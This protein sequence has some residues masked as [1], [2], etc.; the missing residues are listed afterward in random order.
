[1]IRF[2]LV[3]AA[4]LAALPAAAPPAAARDAE[5]H[6]RLDRVT[7]Y[8]DGASVVRLVTFDL[9]PGET[10]LVAR[11]FPAALDPR[12]LRVEGVGGGVSVLGV[13]A[14]TL[15]AEEQ[16]AGADAL[17]A[18]LDALRLEREGVQSRIE[19]LAVRKSFAERY[20]RDVPFGAGEKETKIPF[21]EWRQTFSGLADE[22]EAAGRAL[23][24]V[25]ERARTLDEAIAK[26]EQDLR[27]KPV[28]RVQVRIDVAAE[29]AAKGTLAVTYSVRNARWTPLY[30][31]RLTAGKPGGT[32]SL[33]LVRRAEIVQR[34]GED[35]TDVALSVSTLRTAG[36]TQAPEIQPVF[37]RFLPPPRPMPAPARAPMLKQSD[38]LAE[39]AAPAAAPPPVPANE[40]PVSEREAQA[41]EGALQVVWTLPG[42]VSVGSGEG[43]RVLR[44]ASATVAP[45]LSVKVSAA[46]DTTPYLQAGF[47]HA[48]DAPLLPGRVA[49]YRDGILVGTGRLDLVTQGETVSLGFGAD[50]RTKVTRT[51]LRRDESQ[52]GLVSQS[53][54]ERQEM[55]ISVRNAHDVPM[56]ITVEDRIPQSEDQDIQVEL[57]SGGTAPTARDVGDRRGVLAW[58]YDYAPGESRTITFGWRV[59][60]PADRQVITATPRR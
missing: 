8:P 19:A 45:D 15:D 46:I 11:D 33:E 60:W 4:L 47:K 59:K 12:S 38:A 9:P 18:K 24:E 43:G 58:S 50:E 34:T 17:K 14:K 42:R 56:R 44:L 49:L 52:S 7:V 28:S 5:V 31:A 29:A 16:P 26:A 23:I 20:A 40:V 53:R 36:G 22:I 41:A 10:T 30:D 55:K 35:W 25:R 32:P 1:M 3:S 2:L 13:V 48:E 39:R 57:A 6:S 54:V 37:V 51:L 21:A 27:A